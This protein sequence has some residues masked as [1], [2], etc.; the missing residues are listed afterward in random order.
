M[1]S[2]IAPRSVLLL[3]CC[4]AAGCGARTTEW[5]RRAAA[6]SPATPRASASPAAAPPRDSAR[7][8]IG[9]AHPT[10]LLAAASDAS[11]AALCQARA[12][13]DGDD[14]VALRTAPGGALSG[15]RAR[16]YFVAGGG[17]G[18][19]IDELLAF[20]P[21]GRFVAVRRGRRLILIDA[22]Q[23]RETELAGGAADLEADGLPFRQHRSVAFDRAGTRL[24][25]L[26]R[27]ASHSEVVVR[28]LA[29]GEERALAAGA[30]EIV[31]VEFVGAASWLLV[32]AAADD[33]DGNG[34]LEWPT[35][36]LVVNDAQC[37]TTN[38]RFPVWLPRGD[39]PRPRLARPNGTHFED[40]PGFVTVLGD[41]F[42]IR[43]RSE[44]LVWRAAA[45]ASDADAG[46]AAR[47][48]EL[49]PAA[50]AGRIVYAD[51]ARE[52]LVVGC[53][54][55]G[56]RWPLRLA[57]RGYSA[58]LGIDLAPAELLRPCEATPRLL[59]L[60][61]GRESVLLDL[62]RRVLV[63]L[64]AGD[65]V[66]CTH[67]RTALVQRAGELWTF[68]VESGA[69]TFLKGDLAAQPDVLLS[70]PAVYVA[71]WVVDVREGKVLGR[72]DAP[73]PPL[74]LAESGQLLVWAA[75]KAPG[76]GADLPRGPLRWTEP[77]P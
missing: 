57:A 13:T 71:P 69:R 32:H 40:V 72:Y 27:G 36:R 65:L 54:A 25:Y 53:S 77:R 6:P 58:E 64:Q 41:G 76:N 44:R 62:E 73:R 56:A 10:R 35:P 5:P 16:P 21:G 60:Y 49:V 31:R 45:S 50:C 4:A 74:A 63:P 1:R 46:T 52:A 9:T 14:R 55:A 17:A 7:F 48:M 3:V 59:A 8:E 20:A 18:A 24:L 30:G 33:T 75:A 23:R 15:D 34:R 43:E 37:A 12:D 11:W 2:V 22:S 70:S 61:P 19:A 51:A 66:L 28:E 42:V 68:D 47:D 26:R 29:S 38:T 67:G 39:V